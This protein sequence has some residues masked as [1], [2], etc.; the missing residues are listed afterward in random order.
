MSRITTSLQRVLIRFWV[1]LIENKTKSLHSD[2]EAHA[3]LF[4]LS[5]L[6]K[7]SLQQIQPKIFVYVCSYEHI[8]K[9]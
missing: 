2:I 6:S 9:C 5:Q 7:T 4:D 3:F 1:N 8:A